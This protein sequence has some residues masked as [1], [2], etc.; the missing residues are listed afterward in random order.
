MNIE[1]INERLSTV[2]AFLL[3]GNSGFLDDII[4]SLKPIKNIRTVLQNLRK[5]V[6][7]TNQKQGGGTSVPIWSNLLSF[8]FYTLKIRDLIE[9]VNG[10]ENVSIRNKILNSFVGENIARIGRS[11]TEVIDLEESKNQQKPVVNPNQDTELDELKR[12]YNGLESWLVEVA[13]HIKAAL[14]SIY[15]NLEQPLEVGY[16]PRIG[17]VIQVPVELGT[18][19]ETFFESI[20]RPWQLIFTVQGFANYK[21]VEMEEMD[22][23]FGDLWYIIGDKEIEIVHDLAQKVLEEEI[24]LATVSDICGELDCLVALAQGARLHNLTRPV[25][26]KDNVIDIQGGRHLLQELSVPAYVAN[27]TFVVGGHGFS[28][29][30]T[31]AASGGADGAND[32]PQPPI[33]S[34]DV[35]ED[36][37]SMLIMTGPNYSGKS[38]YLKQVALIVYM[39]HIGR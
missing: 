22:E 1:V 13:K 29:L 18:T 6:S 12:Q 34:S 19:F 26:T 17:Y 11:I 20:D 35:H 15:Q 21:S 36:G 27:D 33:I 7:G 10:L 5:G 9:E 38:V 8:A 28:E 31:D 3:P 37:P 16:Y 14:P 25:L 32:T 2:S 24:L 30:N 39:A 23:K 4:S